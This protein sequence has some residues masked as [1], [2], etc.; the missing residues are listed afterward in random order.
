MLATMVPDKTTAMISQGIHNAGSDF[1]L[2][3]LFR[4][5][6]QYTLFENPTIRNERKRNI[7]FKWVDVAI[8]TLSVFDLISLILNV[9]YEHAFICETA[10]MSNGEKLMSFIPNGAGFYVHMVYVYILLMLS[11]ILLAAKIYSTPGFYR[12]QYILTLVVI[13]VAAFIDIVNNIVGIALDFSLYSYVLL[14]IFFCIYPIFYIPRYLTTR[15]V[16]EAA[17]VMSGGVICFDEH[18]EC[19]Y[20]NEHVLKL[21]PMARN[22]HELSREFR[23]WI[24]CENVK[25]FASDVV[26]KVIGKGIHTEYY[27]I[28]CSRLVDKNGEYLGSFFLLSNRTE[29]VKRLDRERY[30][31]THDTMTKIYNR[32]RFYIETEKMLKN[33]PDTV[34]Y[35]VC[36]NV[37]DLKLVNEL[38][39]IGKGN[40][41]L[42]AFAN[43]LSEYVKPGAVYG[44]LESDHFAMCIPKVRFVEEEF[45]NHVRKIGETIDCDAYHTH[46]YLGIYEIKDITMPVPSMCDHAM[47]A[48][49]SV[50]G[51]YQYCAVYYTE[52]M[53]SGAL[54]EKNLVSEFD[55]AMEK[56][57]FH[58]FL[59]PQ[60]DA[61]GNMLG[62]EALVR[63]IHP[64]K[65]M[66][67]PGS[68]ISVFEKTGI[69]YKLDQ[70][71]WR[72]ACEK[73]KDWKDRGL[74]QY[75]ISV[76]IS[77]RD[78]YYLDIYSTFV[79]L[80]SEYHISPASLKLEI[81]ETALMSDFDKQFMLMKRLREY[82]FHIEIDDFG[83]GYSSL[84]MLKDMPVD[85]LKI[86]MGFL[87]QTEHVRRSRIILETIVSLSKK[88][89]MPVV[90]EG[91]ETKEQLAFL[92][93]LECEAYQ[94]YY[95]SKPISVEE[96]EKK[97]M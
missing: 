8:I 39:G 3:F 90:V 97:Y 55:S 54:Y 41:L 15:V 71:I 59:Q 80:V 22:H 91:V 34:Y 27:D 53:M 77:P 57:Q 94:G 89:E 49:D 11:V 48:I 58:M 40:E 9:R 88:L 69:I 92:K 50:K 4:F 75:Y 30:L 65:G 19:V 87:R 35:M 61:D 10:V 33:N 86:D 31:A 93:E 60:T 79:D 5:I 25:D 47:L 23:D 1:M 26:R 7:V 67:P 62:A 82:G 42:I 52:D 78:F 37:K 13:A 83:S 81:T 68:F 6:R 16:R 29:D 32:D 73:L 64:E 21:F 2:F 20:A 72:C 14:G 56:E 18:Q 70:Y 85:V 38:F 44:R 36:S 12:N 96:F 84:N 45:I 76:N 95:F 51:D 66:I 28:E 17:E 46:I 24:E 63:W 43:T 74:S